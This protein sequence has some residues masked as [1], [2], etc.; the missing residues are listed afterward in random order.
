MLTMA[1]KEPGSISRTT[2]AAPVYIGD[3]TTVAP[4][5]L[6]V[7][8]TGSS[9]TEY[10]LLMLRGVRNRPLKWSYRRGSERSLTRAMRGGGAPLTVPG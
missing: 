7:L 8:L 10:L 6:G 4:I 1:I 3:A 9:S 5:T 2:P